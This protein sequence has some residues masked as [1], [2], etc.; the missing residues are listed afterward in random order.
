MNKRINN[1]EFRWSDHNKSHE[2]VQWFNNT[3]KEYCIVVA[4]FKLDKKEARSDMETVGVRWLDCYKEYPKE[5]IA[6]TE[7]AHNAI[8]A[9]LRLEKDMR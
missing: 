3:G 1:V 7:Y 4:F 5:T 9:E 6:L 2:L 8:N